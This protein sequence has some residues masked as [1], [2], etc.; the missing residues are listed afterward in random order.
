MW[1]LIALLICQVQLGWV[2]PKTLNYYIITCA[3]KS[4]CSPSYVKETASVCVD[5]THLIRYYQQRQLVGIQLLS[6]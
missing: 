4:L 3:S 5:Y 2:E 6:L 1:P